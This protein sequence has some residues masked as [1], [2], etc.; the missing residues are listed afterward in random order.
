MGNTED[1]LV[2]QHTLIT[3]KLVNTGGCETGWLE[4]NGHC[5][6]RGH[7][8]VNWPDAKTECS[9]RCSYLIEIESKEEA[10][11]ISA[12]FLENVN[13]GSDIF[14]DCTA[15]TGLNDL[16]IEGT[17][18]WDHSNAPLTFSNW[19][20][21][22]PSLG[23]PSQAQTRDFA[24]HFPDRQNVAVYSKLDTFAINNST[25]PM[26]D[27]EGVS[28]IRC[29]E[30]C[31]GESCCKGFMYDGNA[32]RCVGVHF[33]DFDYTAN[34]NNTF[35]DIDGMLPYQKGCETGWLEFKGHCYHRGHLKVQWSEAKIEHRKICS[36][37][38]EID[39]I[40]ESNWISSTFLENE[41]CST[42]RF[43]DC[44]AWNGLNDL[45]IEGTFI[46]DHSNASLSFT[47]WH[48]GEPSVAA[49]AQAPTRDCGEIFRGGTWN[50][51]TCSHVNWFICEK[52]F[53][54]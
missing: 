16:D 12:T 47:N 3:P 30:F 38:V 29:G 31:L 11:W 54:Q 50:D 52:Q 41:N 8:K 39:S 20:S 10:E 35:S 9:K 43:Q 25:M 33:G 32:Q 49:P 17:Y 24:S 40:E 5:Y 21:H 4:F 28:R 18:V 45:D 23:T 36:Y 34:L 19:H 13:C 51:R 48:A 22:E 14:F 37:L 26:F 7:T 27:L 6:F 44:T 1:A 15:W 2:L 46:W 42:I 53:E